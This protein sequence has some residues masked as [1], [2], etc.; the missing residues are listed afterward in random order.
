VSENLAKVGLVGIED[1]YP[2]ELSGGM[3][4]RVALARAI[5]SE[6]DRGADGNSDGSGTDGIEEV[7]LY[8]IPLYTQQISSPLSLSLSLSS[9]S[10]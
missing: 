8:V 5:T 4:K 7:V 9:H 6:S 10:L 2:S 3:K 1:R